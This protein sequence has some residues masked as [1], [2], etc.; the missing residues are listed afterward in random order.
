MAEALLG[1]GSTGAASLNQELIDKLK[2]AERKATVEPIET[3]IE[4]ITAD[5]EKFDEVNQAVLD[6]LSAIRPFDLF[7]TEGV[8]AFEEKSATTSGDSVIFDA[9]DITSLNNGFTTVNVTQIGQKDVFQS[10]LI[11]KTNIYDEANDNA[12]IPFTESIG[13]LTITIGEQIFEFATGTISDLTATPPVYSS[14][15]ELTKAINAKEGVYA[16]LDEVSSGSYR[17]I[18]KSEDVGSSNAIIIGGEASVKLGYNNDTYTSSNFADSAITPTTLSDNL[19]INTDGTDYTIDIANK[20]YEDI[21][22][23]INDLNADVHASIIDNGNGTFNLKISN[24]NNSLISVSGTASTTLG[25]TAARIEESANHTLKAQD[26][27]MT[28]DGVDFE[29]SSNEIVVDGLT[30]TANKEGISTINIK[31]DTSVLETQMQD[32][33]DKY[34]ILAG[35]VNEATQA[36]S[37]MYNKSGLKAI[38]EQIRGRLF[39]SYGA[40][41][42]KSLFAIG[43][44]FD[45]DLSGK[46]SFD[47]T[48]FN[49]AVSND[50]EGLKELFI[51]DAENE[52]FG[53]QL[54]ALL[55]EMFFSSGAVSLFE[56]S[57]NNRKETLNTDLEKAEETLNTKYDQLTAQFAAYASIITQ[58]ETAFGGLKMMIDQSIASN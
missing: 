19:V 17:L 44:G 16:S 34:N 52:G 39:D 29:A 28:V 33:V 27:K 31:N 18:V 53:T 26:M 7:V 42:D 15:D 13:N 57:L 22:T 24:T 2:S 58:F 48:T 3:D 25:L 40:N 46:L 1:L 36:D 30:I 9:T 55:D 32:L 12:V 37:E 8:N 47:A 11:S 41:S 38:V 14:Y 45:A 5:I 51:G 23:A 4:N 6:V 35:L 43:F 49:E 54:K 56:T 50:I 10:D 21:V 20:S